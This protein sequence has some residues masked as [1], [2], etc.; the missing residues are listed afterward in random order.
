[1]PWGFEALHA[2]FPLA[3]GLVGVLG[4]VVQIAVLPVFDARQKLPFC[5]PIAFQLIGDDDPWDIVTAFEELAEELLGGL[6]IP[7]TLDQNVEDMAVPIDGSPEIMTLT[8]DGQKDLIQMPLIPRLR[9]AV[10]PLISIRLAKLATPFPDGFVGY[11]HP[12]CKEQLFHIT[13][14]ETKAEAQPHTM[15]DDLRW[16]PMVLVG[17]S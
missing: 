5:G 4:P 11:H 8:L 16:K 15:T 10:A 7:P 17:R 6:L 2:P 9:S 1:V 12:A 13:V 3:G 14:A